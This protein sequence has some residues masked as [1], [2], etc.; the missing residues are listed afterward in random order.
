[1]S[2]TSEMATLQTAWRTAAKRP[3]GLIIN[4][5]DMATARNLRFRFYAA[6]KP[7][8]EGRFTGDLELVNAVGLLKVSVR[9]QPSPAVMLVPK[10][11]LDLVQSALAELGVT[12]ESAV[13]A[14]DVEAQQALLRVLDKTAEGGARDQER[15]DRIDGLFP[16]GASGA[17]GT[18][19]P[20]GTTPF[21]TREIAK[22]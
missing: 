3:E 10:T 11:G 12:T 15:L 4:C 20:P 6:V 18:A 7:V 22:D 19:N 9:E 5:P 16:S 17:S 13:T 14:E 21:Y 8:R 2:K 1:M